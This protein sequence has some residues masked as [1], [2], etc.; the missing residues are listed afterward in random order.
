M[1]TLIGN[2]QLFLFH[3][4]AVSKVLFNFQDAL[5]IFDEQK[6]NDLESEAKG[7][8]LMND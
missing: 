3:S 8:F 7:Q 4:V 6:R 1:G 2:N 5:N